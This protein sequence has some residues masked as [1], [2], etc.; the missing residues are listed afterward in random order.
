MLICQIVVQLTIQIK[1]GVGWLPVYSVT[2]VVIWC[3]VC[4]CVQEGKV[5]I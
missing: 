3:Y 1:V 4:V 2:Q 5:V